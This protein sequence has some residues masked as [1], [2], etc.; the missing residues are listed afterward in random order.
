MRCILRKRRDVS[1][2]RMVLNMLL[3][4]RVIENIMHDNSIGCK[5]E[6]AGA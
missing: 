2:S 6:Y 5:S 4:K 3:L 1:S